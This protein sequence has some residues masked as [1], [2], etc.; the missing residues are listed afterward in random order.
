MCGI[1]GLYGA[2]NL[3]TVHQMLDLIRHR[4]P[5]GRDVW[6]PVDA[7]IILGHVRLAIMDVVGGKQPISNEDNTLWTIVNGEIYNYPALREELV[8]RHKFKT[9]SDSEIVLHLFEERGPAFVEGL[10]GMFAIA[11]WGKECGLY[12]ARDPLGIKP[13]YYGQDGTGVIYFASEIKALVPV[14]PVIH[15]FPNGH[16]MFAGREPIRYYTVP[17]PRAIITDPDEAIT[18]VDGVLRACI[19]KELMSDVPLGTFLS[20]GLDSSL[21]T[22]IAKG[23][24]DGPLHTFSVGLEGSP[25]ISYARIAS[26]AI[27]TNHHERVLTRDDVI[28]AIP[29]VISALE[30]F[31]PALVRSAIPTHF[32]S[33]LASRSVRVVLSGEG[34]DELFAGYQYLKPLAENAG[35]ETS[36]LDDELFLITSSLHNTNLQRADRLTMLHGLEGRVPFLETAMVEAAFKIA[37]SLK[38]SGSEKWILRRVAERYLP[39]SIAWREKEKFSIGTGIGQLLEQHAAEVVRDADFRV[40]NE[41]REA[42]GRSTFKT[43]EEYLYWTFF[44]ERYGREDIVGTVGR[45]RSLNPEQL[46]A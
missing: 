6:S 7:D 18:L 5:D 3:A 10:E 29:S 32:V 27:G 14:V 20:G 45:S 38:I 16:Y 46:W 2:R 31:D 9:R 37:N 41:S 1:A 42:R 21:V 33:E 40:T 11:L 22:A 13:L 8:S 43:K 25:D 34:A 36:A 15:E 28:T 19:K 39:T 17:R 4:G 30:S 23:Y 35:G 44:E 26:A 24:M 12:L